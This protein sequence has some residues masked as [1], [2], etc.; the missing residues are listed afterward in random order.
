VATQAIPFEI[1]G[2]LVIIS[3]KVDDQPGYYIIDTGVPNVILN[4][5]YFQGKKSEKIMQGINGEGALVLTRYSKIEIGTN[6]WKGVYVE[7]TKLETIEQA[8]RRPIHGLIGCQLFRNNILV[9]DYEKKE[10]RISSAKNPEI[11]KQD[12]SK[13]SSP[14]SYKFK[15]HIPVINARVGS[16]D[17]NLIVDTGSALNILSK[18]DMEKLNSKLIE[19]DK[20]RLAGLGKAEV[21]AEA[22]T[23]FDL[24]IGAMKCEPMKT[25]FSFDEHIQALC[26]GRSVDGVLG[27]EYLSQVCMT[28]NFKERTISLINLNNSQNFDLSD[29][30]KLKKW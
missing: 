15:G 7:I 20:Q 12:K 6:K 14:G 9:F 10:I 4:N 16:I 26:P 17:L 29:D 13:S 8:L 3:A 28:I 19:W 25:L 23:V 27:Y 24:E 1:V 18:N 5:N 30:S 21:R 22:G 2:N 11:Q